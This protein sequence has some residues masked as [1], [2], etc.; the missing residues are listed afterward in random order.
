MKA[1]AIRYHANFYHSAT[2]FSGLSAGEYISI[3]SSTPVVRVT[4]PPVGHVYV[5][6]ENAIVDKLLTGSAGAYNWAVSN[7]RCSVRKALIRTPDEVEYTYKLMSL[8]A[9]EEIKGI[10]SAH[11]YPYLSTSHWLSD[12]PVH[13][14]DFIADGTPG[15]T[16][17]AN[18]QTLPDL[19][20]SYFRDSSNR[21]APVNL[22]AG[23][24]IGT[25]YSD[26]LSLITPGMP[27]G[28]AR[29][30]ISLE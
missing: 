12:A 28:N 7:S 23:G 4:V 3:D 27:F 2:R 13:I 14:S 1:A 16:P 18:S 5:H 11:L 21:E 26:F 29:C 10:P 6:S 20:I 24:V 15:Y 17:S 25:T 30:M 9:W 19:K 8:N 22:I